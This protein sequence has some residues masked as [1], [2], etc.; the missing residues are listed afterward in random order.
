MQAPLTVPEYSRYRACICRP[1]F[2]LRLRNNAPLLPPLF[3]L[4]PVRQYGLASELCPA[5]FRRASQY[6]PGFWDNSGDTKTVLPCPLPEKREKGMFVPSSLDNNVPQDIGTFASSRFCVGRL[7]LRV[8]SGIPSQSL[9]LQ[10]GRPF[11]RGG[12][13]RMWRSGGG[14]LPQIVSGSSI[15]P[16]P[17]S[18]EP[19]CWTQNFGRKTPLPVYFRKPALFP[20]MNP[21]IC[22]AE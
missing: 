1:P 16:T 15:V 2:R 10:P 22:Q 17:E 7:K 18:E 12:V 19:Y 6:H 21:L 3:C 8:F 4:D 14:Q 9:K 13:Y 11:G 5:D 20:C